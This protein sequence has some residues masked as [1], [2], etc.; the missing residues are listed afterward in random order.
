MIQYDI[1]QSDMKHRAK[2]LGY[3]VRF[4]RTGDLEIY[5]KGMR[6]AGSFFTSNDQ[7]GRAEAITFM[8]DDRQERF[9]KRLHGLPISDEIKDAL[10]QWH[11]YHGEEW[12][13]RLL[14]QAWFCGR[15]DGFSGT[16]VESTLQR[17]RNTNGH[18]VLEQIDP[19]RFATC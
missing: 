7:Q 12:M 2:N 13:D 5:P 1:T 14:Y 8:R 4:E 17:L 10:I 18:E 3:C 19:K 16:N 6:G 11:A 9:A 15:Y